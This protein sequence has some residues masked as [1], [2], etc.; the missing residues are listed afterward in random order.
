MRQ[1]PAPLEIPDRPSRIV[2]VPLPGGG[3]LVFW[4]PNEKRQ[5]QLLRLVSDHFG[6]NATGLQIVAG[7]DR[8]AGI[9][10]MCWSHPTL[11]LEADL[12]WPTL[13]AIEDP[14]ARERAFDAFGELVLDELEE[15]DWGDRGTVGAAF[16]AVSRVMARNFLGAE[17][18]ERLGFSAAGKGSPG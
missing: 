5:M 1:R 10:G 4:L 6:D 16:S 17:A 11:V 18:E 2:R 12:D 15:Q 8:I 9:L 14:A 7:L 3:D 13:D